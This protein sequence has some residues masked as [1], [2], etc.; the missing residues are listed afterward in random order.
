MLPS[1][2]SA[3]LLLSLVTAPSGDEDLAARVK[4]LEEENA[5]FKR[6]FGVI[7]EEFE[8]FDLGSILLPVGE[9]QHGLGPAASKVYGADGL[10]IGGYGQALYQD[11]NGGKNTF[12]LERAILYVGYKFSEKW[13]F[14][15]ELEIEHGSTSKSGSTSVEF[16]YLDYLHSEIFGVRVGLVLIPMGFINELH[17]PA[18]YLS[19]ARPETER[20]IIPSTWRENGLGVFGDA[21][22]VS[23]RVFVVNGLDATGFSASGLRGGRQK[24]SKAMAD[25]FA[26][27]ARVDWTDTPGLLAGFS[28]YHGGSGQDQAGLG[29]TDTTIVE[30]HAEWKSGPLWLRGLWAQ[31]TVD[32][33]AQLNAAGGLTGAASVGEELNG[34]YVEAGY[35]I[36]SFLAPDSDAALRRFVRFETLD[37]Q[38]DF[39]SG[40]MS[41]SSNDLDIVTLGLQYEPYPSLVFNLDFQDRDDGDDRV[42]FGMGYAF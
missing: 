20:R 12:D 3:A 21:G 6:R 2:L 37:T 34:G 4:K 18:T 25:D 14:N 29:S 13:V 24:G 32:D 26:I 5:E 40:F 8:R 30:V 16:A 9:S 17:E 15:S 7:D 28:A 35:D 10:A 36:L 22:P 19:A 11:L 27:V 41:A 38:A 33:V 39:P 42:H 31:A 1:V 23:Y